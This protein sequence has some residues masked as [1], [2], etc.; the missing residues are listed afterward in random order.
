MTTNLKCD[1]ACQMYYQ[2]NPIFIVVNNLTIIQN[3]IYLLNPFNQD[4]RY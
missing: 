3:K 2:L 1:R 4:C